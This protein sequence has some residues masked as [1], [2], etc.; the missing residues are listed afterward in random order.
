MSG[1]LTLPVMLG[2]LAWAVLMPAP[3]QRPQRVAGLVLVATVG[4]AASFLAAPLLL[5]L[6]TAIGRSPAGRPILLV[7][8][9]LL[10]AAILV[11]DGRA[12]ASDGRG[13]G[14]Q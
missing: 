10:V 5:G 6:A 1:L 4:V 12:T 14:E 2:G 7:L 11:S 9:A 3:S 13:K 8:I